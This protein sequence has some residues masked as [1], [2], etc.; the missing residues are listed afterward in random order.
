LRT[1]YS[2]FLTD[3][4]RKPVA[5]FFRNLKT[6]PALSQTKVIDQ[7]TM[8]KISILYKKVQGYFNAGQ[9]ITLKTSMANYGRPSGILPSLT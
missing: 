4:L 9:L 3:L 6:S 8:S 2:I 1:A 5:D 7:K